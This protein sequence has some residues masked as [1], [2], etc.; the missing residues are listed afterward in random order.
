MTR[1]VQL[2]LHNLLCEKANHIWGFSFAFCRKK[3]AC[4][5]YRFDVVL[6]GVIEV[7]ASYQNFFHSFRINFEIVFKLIKPKKKKLKYSLLS[8]NGHLYKTRGTSVKRTL[9]VGPCLSLL[10]LFDSLKDGHLSKTDTYCRSPRCPSQKE[11]TLPC[12]LWH[13]SLNFFFL[14]FQAQKCTWISGA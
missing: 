11:L 3:K 1:T 7:L 4:F 12:W 9:R 5:T 10:L 14:P 13:R 2:P 6:Q 8:L